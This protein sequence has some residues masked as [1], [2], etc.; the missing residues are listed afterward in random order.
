MYK[1]FFIALIIT[2]GFFFFEISAANKAYITNQGD[3][4]V[5]LINLDKL[6]VEKKIKVGQKPLGITILKRNP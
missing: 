6:E 2:S 4:T 3:D 1:F 5:S